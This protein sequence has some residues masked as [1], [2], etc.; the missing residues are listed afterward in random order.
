MVTKRLSLD[1]CVLPQYESQSETDEGNVLEDNGEYNGND[2][3]VDVL[4]K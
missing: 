3:G 4:L 2:V 1:Q